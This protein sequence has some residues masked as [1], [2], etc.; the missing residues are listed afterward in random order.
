MQMP[1]KTWRRCLEPSIT[2]KWT[3]TVSPALNAGTSR[4][5][6]RSM[7]ST[8]VLIGRVGPWTERG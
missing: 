2:L 8:I 3:R 4:S 1:S 7:L 6:R 5:W